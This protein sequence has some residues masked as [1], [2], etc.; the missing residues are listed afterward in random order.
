MK[1]KGYSVAIKIRH[2]TVEP[3]GLIETDAFWDGYKAGLAGG[4]NEGMRR[5]RLDRPVTEETVVNIIRNL[6]EIA[7][8]G[9]LSESILRQD[10]GR[11]V[12]WIV[13]AV[14]PERAC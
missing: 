2:E 1:G 3:A 6:T 14:T 12:G 7:V 10:V 11:I 4:V 13:G 8:E 9:R 5:F